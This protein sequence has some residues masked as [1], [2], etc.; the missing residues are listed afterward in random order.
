MAPLAAMLSRLGRV[1]AGISAPVT[2]PADGNAV[3]T[4]DARGQVAAQPGKGAGEGIANASP[5]PQRQIISPRDITGSVARTPA[6][7]NGRLIARDRHIAEYRGKTTSGSEHVPTGGTPNP[8][9]DGP[10]RPSWRMLNRTLS[11]QIGTDATRFLDNTA[12]HAKTTA[13]GR[14]YPLGQQDG[15]VQRVYGGT[16]GLANYRPYGSRK[17]ITGGPAPKVVALPGGPYKAG[18]LLSAAGPGDGPQTVW[19]GYPHGLVTRV[20]EPSKLTGTVIRG[21]LGQVRTPYVSRPLNSR[22]AGQSMSQAAVHLDGRQAVRIPKLKP[23]R[24]PGV[25]GRFRAV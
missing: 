22:A 18:T 21:R 20:A 15:S 19:G 7:Q 8:E 14:P 25:N 9:A 10:P 2:G 13:G 24:Q 6:F 23:G 16:P 4:S 1:P 17:P 3:V 12:F 5:Y 11:W